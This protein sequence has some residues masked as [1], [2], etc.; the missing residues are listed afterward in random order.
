MRAAFTSSAARGRPAWRDDR[1][2]KVVDAAGAW[3]SAVASSHRAATR[4]GM[5]VGVCSVEAVPQRSEGR[6]RRESTHVRGAEPPE[7]LAVTILWGR[8][9]AGSSHEMRLGRVPTAT[10]TVSPMHTSL[11][12]RGGE[13]WGGGS[14]SCRG[15]TGRG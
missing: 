7:K 9:E 4:A 1:L 13:M 12:W 3:A 2:L 8:A 14:A 6:V 10:T 5:C 11:A 15:G